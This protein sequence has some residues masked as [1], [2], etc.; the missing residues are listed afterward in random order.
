MHKAYLIFFILV[1]TTLFPLYIA[2]GKLTKDAKYALIC[3]ANLKRIGIALLNYESEHGVL[4]V[5]DN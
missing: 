4:P 1:F 5:A 3:K 2:S